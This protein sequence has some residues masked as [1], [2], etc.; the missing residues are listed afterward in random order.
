MSKH[1][2]ITLVFLITFQSFPASDPYFIKSVAFHQGGQ[3]VVPIFK[4]NERFFFS[5]DDLLGD[6]SDYYYNIVHCTADW[7]VS[8]LKITEYLNGIQNMRIESLRPSFNT[9]QPFVNYSIGFPNQNTQILI[10]GNY[11]IQ[12]FNQQNEMLIERRFVLYEDLAA[13]RMEIKRPRNFN[14]SSVKQNVYLT[15]DFSAETLQNPS[16]SVQLVLLQNGQWYNA[17]TGLKPQYILGDKFQYQYDD[18]T[19]FWAGN[20]FLFFDNSD[21]RRVNNTV[22]KVRRDELYEVFLYP[23]SPMK[24]NNTYVYYQDVNGAFIPRNRY[25]EDPVIESDY[26]WVYF[27]YHLEQLPVDQKLYIVGMFNDYQFNELYEMKYDSQLGVYKTA[28][29]LKQGFTNY[30]Y[31]ITSKDGVV[32]EALNPDGNFVETENEY[33]GLVYYQADG[34]RYARV[35]GFGKAA[36]KMIT[37]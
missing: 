11:L 8:D 20:E 23:R 36:S 34:D 37:N 31:V 5:F 15:L 7:K 24:N 2:L 19:S 17:I 1:L 30:K 12:V 9:F 14:F 25:R 4:T 6:E 10:S 21:L 32:L 33:Y 16:K 35:I 26:T 29:F 13:V 3:S 28:L 22:S 27:T 18:E